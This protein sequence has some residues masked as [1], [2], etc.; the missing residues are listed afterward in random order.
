MRAAVLCSA[1]VMVVK[2]TRTASM[3]LRKTQQYRDEQAYILTLSLCTHTT[4]EERTKKAAAIL[5]LLLPS[6]Y[7][8]RAEQRR[9]ALKLHSKFEQKD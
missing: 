8:I 3:L 9:K 1:A 6:L 2:I 4:G 7:R 5:S